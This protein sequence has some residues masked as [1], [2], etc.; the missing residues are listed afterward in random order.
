MCDHVAEAPGGIGPVA[1]GISVTTSG[2]R[3]RGRP[4]ATG[5]VNM[6][7]PVFPPPPG[8]VYYNVDRI[9]DGSDV[10]LI[11]IRAPAHNHGPDGTMLY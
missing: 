11:E 5:A 2:W 4:P 8:A 3:S 6:T 7:Q 1:G 10:L 9:S